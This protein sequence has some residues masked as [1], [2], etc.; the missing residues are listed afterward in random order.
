MPNHPLKL[1]IYDLIRVKDF[2][3]LLTFAELH[4]DDEFSFIDETS[5]VCCDMR[6]AQV[7]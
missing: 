5:L 3:F 6:V 1:K 7:T 4:N 2:K